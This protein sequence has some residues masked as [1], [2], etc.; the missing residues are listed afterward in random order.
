[1]LYELFKINN[2][3]TVYTDNKASK[4]IIENCKKND[5]FFIFNIKTLYI[6]YYIYILLLKYFIININILYFIF[7]YQ[8]QYSILII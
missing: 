3:M 4:K 8:Y 1:M 7:Y 2:P 6:F 5:I